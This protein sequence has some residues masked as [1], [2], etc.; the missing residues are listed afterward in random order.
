MAHLAGS[1]GPHI[2]RRRLL[3]AYRAARPKVLLLVAPA[4]CG[5][6]MLA[7]QIAADTR[8]ASVVCDCAGAA[9]AQE[10][11]RRM[12]S[13]LAEETPQRGASLAQISLAI[14]ETQSRGAAALAPA[15]SAWSA[16]AA[17]A[18]FVF[19]NAE[20]LES[21]RSALDLVVDLLV[22]RPESRLVII[23]SRVNLRLNFA[24]FAS[25]REVLALHAREMLFDRE[26]LRAMFQGL[27]TD[28][29]FNERMAELSQGWPIGAQ[30]LRGIAAE[31]A[32]Q[33][34]LKRLDRLRFDDLYEYLSAEVLRSYPDATLRAL[35][36][37]AALPEATADDVAL[38]LNVADAEPLLDALVADSPFL[39]KTSQHAYVVHPL[40][41]ATL[42][43]KYASDI[44]TLPRTVAQAWLSR[45]AFVRAAELFAVAG[46][47]AAAA[48]ALNEIEIME[49]SAFSSSYARTLAALDTLTFA[50]Y[51]RLFASSMNY[52]QYFVSPHALMAET[53]SV[54]R[55]LP[56]D[57]PL[58][59]RAYIDY[60]RIEFHDQ[61]GEIE[62]ARRI[63]EDL[64]AAARI[65][66]VPENSF[67]AHVMLY[68]AVNTAMRGKLDEAE[69]LF[70]A[71]WP[72]V[73]SLDQ[74]AGAASLSRAALVARVRGHRNI[75]T[76]LL[77]TALERLRRAG[78]TCRLARAHAEI[79]F[80]A[81]LAGDDR[82]LE[83]GVALLSDSVERDGVAGFAHLLSCARGL[84]DDPP[85]GIETPAWLSQAH[86]IACAQRP[87]T[88]RALAHADA[89]LI[90]AD[91]SGLPLLRVLARIAVAEKAPER[92]ARRVAEAAAL[93]EAT[94]SPELLAAVREFAAGSQDAGMLGAFVTRLR[95]RKPALV[96]L[97]IEYA[98]GAVGCRGRAVSLRPR[99]LALLMLVARSALPVPS[100]RLARTLWPDASDRSARNALKTTLHRLRR[101]LGDPRL[102]VTGGDGLELRERPETDLST[103]GQALRLASAPGPLSEDARARLRAAFEKLRRPRPLRLQS[104]DWYEPLA[105]QFMEW[106]RVFATRLAADA[107]E[108]HEYAHALGL[109]RSAIEIDQYDEQPQELQ[110]R[111]LMALGDHKAAARS[112]RDYRAL[113][114]DELDVGPPAD[115]ATLVRGAGRM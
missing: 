66:G 103:F 107:L 97:S 90:A 62:E 67:H 111:A 34:G 72:K 22:N 1:A 79:V 13:S 23:C 24:R 51:P 17:P 68:R 110:I 85:S 58:P 70:E 109:A 7:R 83:R 89:A 61:L 93:A 9:G 88:Q 82:D 10:L 106:T 63:A 87:D 25:G 5:K 32:A 44:R 101:S 104:W 47:R 73:V 21:N 99:E 56:S 78:I 26:E 77:E 74:A 36:T 100:E 64:Y 55:A 50:A 45:K 57:M 65:P 96:A 86:L 37:C 113:L 15:V 95:R 20:S 71:A 53:E 108:S 8:S 112:F 27:G 75:E 40:M 2:K 4:G 94:Q 29:N 76:R 6:S 14:G 3:A 91:R 35:V 42:L 33:A 11:A 69:C 49:T 28:P 60:F 92:S 30:M 46:D 54:C 48:A 39:S 43:T 105:R 31:P 84:H 38:A 102:L 16:D 52:R 98:S 115:L 19:E 18:M 41:R 80:G 59:L 12:L 81:W 114:K